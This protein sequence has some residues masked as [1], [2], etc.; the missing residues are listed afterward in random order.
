[1]SVIRN[2]LL[3]IHFSEIGAEAYLTGVQIKRKFHCI[4]FNI[5][6]YLEK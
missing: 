4:L 1:M 6:F 3:C 2:I 5:Y